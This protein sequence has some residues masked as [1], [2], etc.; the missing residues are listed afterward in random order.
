MTTKLRASSRLG[1]KWLQI[2]L[3]SMTLLFGYATSFGEQGTTCAEGACYQTAFGQYNY[4]FSLYAMNRS[5]WTYN[6]Y[7]NGFA[8][9]YLCYHYAGYFSDLYSSLAYTPRGAVAG[10][11]SYWYDYWAATGDWYWNNF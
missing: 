11:G 9:P 5:G 10:T 1:A 4:Y 2:S 8:L 3:L 7:Y 6:Y